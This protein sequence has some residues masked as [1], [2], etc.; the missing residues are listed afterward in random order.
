LL[1]GLEDDLAGG[2]RLLVG[3]HHPG[4]GQVHPYPVSVVA[5]DLDPEAVGLEDGCHEVGLD[6][7]TAENH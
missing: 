2:L 1:F 7:L 3:D 4:V 5:E 6:A